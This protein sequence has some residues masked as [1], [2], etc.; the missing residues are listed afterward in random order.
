MRTREP[1][2]SS[3]PGCGLCATTMPAGSAEGT[4]N[5]LATKP[6][7]R[8]LARASSARAQSRLG[9][10]MRPGPDETLTVTVAP[11]A[12]GSPGSGSVATTM[13]GVRSE[14]TARKRSF[15]P[16]PRSRFSA[17]GRGSPIR[18]GT[19]DGPAETISNTSR[20]ASSRL[21][22]P[23]SCRSTRPLGRALVR[24]VTTGRR[25]AAVIRRLASD[26][27]SS[28]TVG[29]LTSLGAGSVRERAIS[30]APARRTSSS[31]S[32]AARERRKRTR[33]TIEWPLGARDDRPPRVLGR[34]RCALRPGCSAGLPG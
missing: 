18:R 21:P 24:R 7:L 3:A 33:Q 26:S 22:P 20:A 17:T 2:L 29:T 11:G 12:A 30:T 15:M 23:G 6:A 5:T 10:E 16:S 25:P 9:T 4:S 8:T 28:T 31:K 14:A 19:T 13:P 27:L 32:R 1:R 34:A